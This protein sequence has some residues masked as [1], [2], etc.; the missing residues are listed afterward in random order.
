MTDY[1]AKL[2]NELMGR[3]RNLMPN[4]QEKKLTWDSPEVSFSFSSGAIGHSFYHARA[5]G[6]VILVMVNH[7]PS[8]K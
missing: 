2:L 1:A 5:A 3:S 6:L 4:E 7:R 8:H